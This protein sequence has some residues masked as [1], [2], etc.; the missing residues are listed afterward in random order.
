[1]PQL[2]ETQ[3]YRLFCDGRLGNPYPLYHQL[4]HQDPVHWCEPWNCWVLTSYDDVQ[5]GH[6]NPNLSSDKT[7]AIMKGLP[8]SLRTR[9]EPLE[10]HLRQWVS[11]TDPPDH[12]RLRGLVNESLVPRVVEA[13]RRHIASVANELIDAMV[14]TARIDLVL[15]FAYPLPVTVICELLGIPAGD[16]AL[17]S[18]WVDDI[19][20]FTDG[21]ASQ[22]AGAAE[23]ALSGLEELTSYFDRII[24]RKRAEPDQDLI[25]MLVELE[26]EGDSLTDAEVMAMCEQILVG[27]HD[28]TTALISNGILAL[29]QSPDEL[30]RLRANTELIT[31]AVEEFL[32]YETPAPRN[33]RIATADI[34]IGGHHIRAGQTVV[35]MLGAANRD[36]QQFPDPDRLDVGRRPNNHV[37]FG[38]GH[39]FCLGKSLAQLE[40]QIS[41]S[42]ILEKLPGLRFADEGMSDEPPWRQSSGLRMLESLPVEFDR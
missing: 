9:V 24:E 25:S 11:H 30:E 4:R 21:P 35:L 26:A 33:T 6:L 1:M 31:T 34:A 7:Q 18:R 23:Q 19:V 17:F 15:D 32:R 8:E 12:T 27:G 14:A 2:R 5:R 16:R 28:T 39:H 3:D 29:L 20:A 41:I 40:G 10:Q 36:P 22:R 37:A 42:A 13:M 38:R